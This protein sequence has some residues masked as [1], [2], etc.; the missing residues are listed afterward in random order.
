MKSPPP[1]A[2]WI[3]D[4]Q[5]MSPAVDSPAG[6]TLGD[7]IPYASGG[8]EDTRTG[9]LEGNDVWMNR[10]QDLEAETVYSQRESPA[11]HRANSASTS[12]SDPIQLLWDLVRSPLR[13]PDQLTSILVAVDWVNRAQDLQ[14]QELNQLVESLDEVRV[15]I[16]FTCSPLNSTVDPQHPQPYQSC[17][18]S[19]F[20]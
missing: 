7:R 8:F 6:A 2:Y 13:S 15:E 4:Y 14:E 20:V 16:A 18:L 1:P 11:N 17:F 3:S 12:P 10:A 9:Q 5:A 19:L